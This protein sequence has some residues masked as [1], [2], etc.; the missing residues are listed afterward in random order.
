LIS[1]KD[2]LSFIFNQE[3]GIVYYGNIRSEYKKL[4]GGDDYSPQKSDIFKKYC[5]DFNDLASYLPEI[6][7]KKANK[8]FRDSMIFVETSANKAFN[9]INEFVEVQGGAAA[10]E[11][12]DAAKKAARELAAAGTKAQKVAKGAGKLAVDVATGKAPKPVKDLAEQAK[13]TVNGVMGATKKKA[14]AV[15]NEGLNAAHRAANK[16]FDSLFAPAP[17]AATPTTKES[18]SLSD[19]R[20]KLL[21]ERLEK[22]TIGLIK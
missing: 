22:L 21:E 3:Q 4:F 16:E 15:I 9:E 6:G 5:K 8:V 12:D 11:L 20:E 13:Q 7:E 19:Y 18:I 17:E 10:K 14:D 1:K 2:V